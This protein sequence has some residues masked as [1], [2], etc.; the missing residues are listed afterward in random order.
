MKVFCSHK[1]ALPYGPGGYLVCGLCGS[2]W[3]AQDAAPFITLGVTDPL[4]VDRYPFTYL[5]GKWEKL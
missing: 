5:N 1:T 2:E 4:E 3:Y